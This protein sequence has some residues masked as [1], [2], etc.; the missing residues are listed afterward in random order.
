VGEDLSGRRPPT[1]G[2]GVTFGDYSFTP[3][4]QVL[5]RATAGDRWTVFTPLPSR[6][7]AGGFGDGNAAAIFADCHVV[8]VAVY[9]EAVTG[10]LVAH[11]GDLINIWTPTVILAA[12]TIENSRLAIQALSDCGAVQVPRLTGFV[13]K[14]VHGFSVALDARRLPR[15]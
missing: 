5:R 8:E 15:S 9:S 10:V 7:T 14:I 4:P 12:G 2:L 11:R 6:R 13:D 1:P 3:T